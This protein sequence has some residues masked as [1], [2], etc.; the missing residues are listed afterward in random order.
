MQL[1]HP[2][3]AVSGGVEGEVLAVLARDPAGQMDVAMLA[4]MTSKSY[5]GVRHAIRRLVQQG[6]VL[7]T[8][9]GSRTVF[10]FNAEHVLANAI[11]EMASAKSRVLDALRDAVEQGFTS[12]PEF[13]VVFGSAA[14]DEMTPDSDIDLFFVRSGSA[15]PDLFDDEA[16]VI[17]ARTSRL[18][19]NDTRILT[20]DLTELE[21]GSDAHPVLAEVARDGVM[22]QGSLS[23]FR[24]R[25]GLLERRRRAAG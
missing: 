18:T 6:T 19:G 16:A 5:T 7:E 3:A 22:L 21:Q 8:T 14:R 23:E 15:D 2:I 24:A 25:I 4:R 17:A 20:Y 13:A 11:T 1:Q 9:I 12:R 10:R